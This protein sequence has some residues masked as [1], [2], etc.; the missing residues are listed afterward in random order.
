M[1]HMCHYIIIIIMNATVSRP[2]IKACTSS[3]TL[4]RVLSTVGEGEEV[5]PS[6]QTL[7]LRIL[8]KMFANS[9]LMLHTKVVKF[10]N[11]CF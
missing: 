5:L 4:S 6:P 8:P 1:L 11:C 10:S 9:S 3:S 7:Q 2:Q